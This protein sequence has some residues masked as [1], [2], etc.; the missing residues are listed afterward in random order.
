MG[1]TRRLDRVSLFGDKLTFLIPHEWIEADDDDEGT[2]L[3]QMPDTHSGWF[4]VSLITVGGAGSPEERLRKSFSDCKEVETNQRTGTLMRRSEHDCVEDGDRLHIY[5][6]FVGGCGAPDVVREAV[7]SYT[8]L[9]EL[10]TDQET[11]AEVRL[12]EQLVREAQFF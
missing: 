6:W 8:V 4:R 11:Q 3:Y 9:A 1:N 5:Y 12:I 7:F 2:Y 10:T